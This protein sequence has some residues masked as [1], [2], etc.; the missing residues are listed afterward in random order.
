MKVVN[1]MERKERGAAQVYL[2]CLGDTLAE[3]FYLDVT[4]RSMQG[5]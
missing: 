2:G 1:R 3:D 5:D 4:D